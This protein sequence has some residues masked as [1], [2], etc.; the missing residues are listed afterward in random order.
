MSV[1]L[2]CKKQMD[3]RV[4]DGVHVE[5]RGGVAHREEPVPSVL[6]KNIGAI[7]DGFSNPNTLLRRV[8]MVVLVTG[9]SGPFDAHHVDRQNVYIVAGPFRD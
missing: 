8:S 2:G 6:R 5:I 4:V 3:D 1:S 9:E 7:V